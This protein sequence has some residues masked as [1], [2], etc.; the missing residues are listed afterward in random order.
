MKLFASSIFFCMTFVAMD[1]PPRLEKNI[2]PYKPSRMVECGLNFFKANEFYALLEAGTPVSWD[3]IEC[4]ASRTVYYKEYFFW[5]NQGKDLLL[6]ANL[7]T[8]VPSLKTQAA[9][10]VSKKLDEKKYNLLPAQLKSLV[11]GSDFEKTMVEFKKLFSLDASSTISDPAMKKNVEDKKQQLRANLW[12]AILEYQSIPFALKVLKR[13]RAEFKKSVDE[14]R[15]IR[16]WTQQLV[17]RI[18]AQILRITEFLRQK[19]ILDRLVTDLDREYTRQ[20]NNLRAIGTD[21]SQMEELKRDTLGLLKADERTC[22]IYV[23][24]QVMK[25]IQP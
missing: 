16:E 20:I 8:Q 25:M 5:L 21:V 17:D 1:K 6:K 12:G 4:L 9:R 2:P 15:E 14:P 22:P 23:T 7:V 11:I 3:D 18:C 24:E 13:L 10:A 19:G